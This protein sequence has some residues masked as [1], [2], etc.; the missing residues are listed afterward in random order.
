[1][2][3]SSPSSPRGH[4][5]LGGLVTLHLLLLY[6]FGVFD[7]SLWTPDEPRVAAVARSA[8]EG[9]W[10]APRLGNEPFLEQPPLFYWVVAAFFRV[11]GWDEPFRARIISTL[12]CLGGLAFTYLLARRLTPDR[13]STHTAWLAVWTLG[14]S[15]EYFHTAHRLVVDSALVCFTTG[16]AHATACLLGARTRGGQVA[17]ILW[18]SVLSSAA[19]LTKGA[20]GVAV[21][22]LFA[23]ACGVHSFV[24]RR[25]AHDSGRS[26]SSFHLPFGV[27]WIPPLVFAAVVGPWLYEL[28]VAVGPRGFET[29]FLDNTLARVV[30]S[31][32]GERAH[33]RPFYYYSKL[34]VHVL[35][36]AFFVLGGVLHRFSRQAPP[37]PEEKR[38]YDISLLWLFAGFAMLSLASTKREVYFIPFYPALAVVGGVWLNALLS[39]RRGRYELALPYLLGSFLVLGAIALVVTLGLVP[40]L[41][42][43][44]L[45]CGAIVATAF[46]WG[47]LHARRSGGVGRALTVWGIGLFAT[48][49]FAFTGLLPA[50]ERMKTL[51]TVSR[52][53]VSMV[54]PQETLY[55]YDP[56][57]TTIAM[58]SLYAGRTAVPVDAPSRLSR[59]LEDDEELYVMAVDKT[60]RRRQRRFEA[61]ETFKSELLLK[62][63]RPSSRAFRL[64][65]VRR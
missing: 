2:S 4:L 22:I 38:T 30:P 43:A 23:I 20:I 27:L 45:W 3:T 55:A 40:S 28:S 49:A 35:P 41:P 7:H 58:V 65:R 59:L 13:A 26:V 31:L 39:G 16:A 56:D 60:Y 17:W 61:V 5:R 11:F 54:P 9:A 10:V 50:A 14:L 57:E 62:D 24:S 42:S 8:A 6:S 12:F 19:F 52:R 32:A 37:S 64:Y 15:L 47:T 34:P 48:S 29:L 18:A 1:M 46:A 63:E 51:S 53:I 44:T 25:T 33:V 21:P 36:A